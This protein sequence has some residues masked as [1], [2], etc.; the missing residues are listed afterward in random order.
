MTWWLVPI[1]ALIWASLVLEGGQDLVILFASIW[2]LNHITLYIRWLPDIFISYAA[3]TAC[4]DRLNQLFQHADIKD[5]LLTAC[6]Q[7][8]VNAK[9]SKLHLRNVSFQYEGQDKEVLSDINLDIDLN[10]YISLIGAVGSGKSTLLKLICAEMKPTGGCIEVEFDDGIRADIWHEDVYE[11]FRRFIGYMPQEAYLSNTTLAVNVSLDTF[12]TEDD[13]M[14]AIRMAE[15]EADIGHWAAGAS[16]EIGETGVN[17]SGGQKQRVNLARALY[18]GRSYLVLDDPLSAVDTDTEANLMR[19]L[20]SESSGFM[21]SS[22]RLSELKKTDRILV[23]ESGRIIEDGSPTD[24][25]NEPTSEFNKQLQAGELKEG[26][27]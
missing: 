7:I 15:L 26:E 16:E 13:V 6:E 17:L 8:G 21:L 14:R 24:L 11:V 22:H 12:H 25:I 9:P 20:L 5:D 27:E 4:V 2:M 1:I 23:L 3:A 19:T 18:S 10:R